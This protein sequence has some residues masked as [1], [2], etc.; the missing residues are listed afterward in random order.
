MRSSSRQQSGIV[1]RREDGS[2][3]W[4]LA[5]RGAA[6]IAV[7]IQCDYPNVRLDLLR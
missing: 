1:A 2:S 7:P 6:A 5:R 3:S 4:R